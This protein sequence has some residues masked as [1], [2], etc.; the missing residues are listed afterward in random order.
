MAFKGDFTPILAKHSKNLN[1]VDL[2]SV[3]VDKIQRNFEP[4]KF[5]INEWRDHELD[6]KDVKLLLYEAFVEGKLAAPNRLLPLV[7]KHY[8]EPEFS[9]FEP[10]TLWSLSNAFTAA[11]KD[12]KPVKQFQMTARLGPFLESYQMPF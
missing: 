1:L 7:H 2:I 3:G 6:D 10:R 9:E 5:Q 12:L 8:F 11:F 4:L